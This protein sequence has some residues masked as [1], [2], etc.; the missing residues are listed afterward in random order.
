MSTPVGPYTPLVRAGDWVVVSGQV[1][2]VDGKLVPGGMDAEL[3]QALA[4]LKGHLDGAGVDLTE[5]KKTMVFLRDMS[6]FARMNEIYVE[7]FGDHRPARSAIG[8]ADLPLGALVE[9]EAWAHTG[10]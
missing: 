8:V 9:I 4:N 3:R 7:F 6:D 1:G 5:V 10:G 2:V